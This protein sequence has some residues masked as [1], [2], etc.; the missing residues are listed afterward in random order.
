MSVRKT[1]K[2][3]T[4]VVA[5]ALDNRI[6]SY[7]RLVP[8]RHLYTIPEQ[9]HL[10][11]FIEHFDVDCIFDVGAN[12]GQYAQ[13]LRQKIG[14]QGEIISFEPIPECVVDLR[15]AAAR[16]PRWHIEAVALSERSGEQS[17]NV[18]VDS[19]FSSLSTPSSSGINLS[20]IGNEITKTISVEV[21]TLEKK[22]QAYKTMLKFN[23]PFLK[24]DTQGNDI[25][26]AKGAGSCLSE[27][28]GLQSE[29]AIVPIYHGVPSYQDAIAYYEQEGFVL[30]ALVPNN[31]GHF[32]RLV[33]IDCIMFNGRLLKS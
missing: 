4:L 15:A 33:E 14:Y 12:R 21:E 32:P 19:V 18:M 11:K 5:A 1:I 28:V 25:L 13:M 16:D 6:A 24:M 3:A 7:F 22:F 29:L 9:E 27:F 23:R 17:F 10:K 20:D 30:S 31:R 26:V 8:T 2:S